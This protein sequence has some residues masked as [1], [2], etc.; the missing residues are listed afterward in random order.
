V[1]YLSVGKGGGSAPKFTSKPAIRMLGSSVI[2]EVSLSADPAPS[3]TWFMG[4]KEVTDGGRYKI[5]TQTDGANYTLLMEI[6]SV[7]A[8]DGGTYKISAKN[9]L[10][11]SNATL[12]LNLQGMSETNLV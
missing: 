12:N 6:L 2:F 9:N 1:I 3:I 10:G 4:D 5:T 8:D 11:V 7:S